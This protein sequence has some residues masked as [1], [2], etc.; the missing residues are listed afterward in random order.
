MSSSEGEPSGEGRHTSQSLSDESHDHGG[1]KTSHGCIQK[2]IQQRIGTVPIGNSVHVYQRDTRQD[3]NPAGNLQSRFI[4]RLVLPLEIFSYE[5][6]N[7]VK[8]L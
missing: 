2:E 3:T 7:F 4:K 6:K 5:R 8:S 1:L